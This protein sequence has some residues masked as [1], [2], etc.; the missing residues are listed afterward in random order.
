[1]K[2]KILQCMKEGRKA[3]GLSLKRLD[4][5]FIEMAGR[6]GLD[7]VH[8]D[9]LHGLVSHAEAEI[10]CRMAIAYGLT[11]SIRLPG[12]EPGCLLNYLDRGVMLAKVP[13]VQSAAECEALVQNT[14][15]APLGRRCATSFSIVLG[16]G[17]IDRKTLYQ[18]M[19]ENL[20]L[21]VQI[22]SEGA[23]NELDK[24]IQIEGLNFFT[25]GRGD[26]AQ[27]MGH[28]GEPNHPEVVAAEEDLFARV[29][30]AGKFVME[31]IQ[32]AVSV[33]GL[34]QNG[35]A[36]LLKSNGRPATVFN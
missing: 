7:Y 32:T 5:E 2:N 23:F 34:V 26:I 25:S 33:A 19:N 30:A 21:V 29:R 8:I 4:V 10:F 13:F 24:I 12:S 36:E 35:C 31:D 15:F 3:L 14:Y 16:G 18:Q 17:G 20:M 9:G 27:F 28:A 6:M 1:M 22:E 11:P